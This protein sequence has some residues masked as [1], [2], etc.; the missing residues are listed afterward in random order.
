MEMCAVLMVVMSL[1]VYPWVKTHRSVQVTY[2]WL[3]PDRAVKKEEARD[4]GTSSEGR[5]PPSPLLPPPW[6]VSCP[7]SYATQPS[8]G[9]GLFCSPTQLSLLTPLP[10]RPSSLLGHSICLQTQ[11]EAVS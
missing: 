9:T 3:Y 4:H 2:V 7:H 11:S 10:H 1:W 6:K 5:L 8:L